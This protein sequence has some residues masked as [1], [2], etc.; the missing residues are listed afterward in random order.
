MMKF[1]ACFMKE[2]AYAIPKY[3][4]EIYFDNSVSK[5]ALGIEYMPIKQSLVEMVN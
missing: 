4:K 3:G 1:Y 5:K 2:A